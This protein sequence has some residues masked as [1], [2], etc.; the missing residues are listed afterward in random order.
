MAASSRLDPLEILGK[1]T[2]S[3]VVDGH[4]VV[5]VRERGRWTELKRCQHR[6]HQ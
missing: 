3:R 6:Q 5:E 4:L 2:R 1:P